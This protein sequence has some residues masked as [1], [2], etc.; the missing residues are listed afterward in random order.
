MCGEWNGLNNNILAF[1]STDVYIVIIDKDPSDPDLRKPGSKNPHQG[2]YVTSVS[3]N[4]EVPQILASASENGL[5]ALWDTKANKSIFQ[6]RD[7]GASTSG[8]RNVAICWSKSISTQ[9]AVTLDDEKHNQLQIWD[10]RNQKGP[11]VVIDKHHTKGINAMDW[12][13]TDPELI[14]TTS[15]DKKLACWNYTQE[16]EPLSHS[17]LSEQALGVK[18]SR[19]LPSIYSVSTA[20]NTY[21]YTLNDANLFSY[22]P[23]WYKVP[24]N[25][26][27]LGNDTLL[28]YSE[29]RG[30][31][32]H[33][34][35][36]PDLN[37]K[38]QIRPKLKALWQAAQQK[39]QEIEGDDLSALLK[40]KSSDSQSEI[41]DYLGFS[42]GKIVQ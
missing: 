11:V 40:A 35:I 31:I 4:R 41:Y 7:S 1:G 3:W 10:L 5:V 12:C 13:Q 24:V 29:E 21:I 17:V 25:S 38:S 37:K 27:I 39:D 15:K 22:V 19:K 28:T 2:S 20:Q 18:W 30:S 23:K 36:I 8:N 9:I 42:K 34:S 26:T 16:Q 33:E 6:F 14:L 32:L